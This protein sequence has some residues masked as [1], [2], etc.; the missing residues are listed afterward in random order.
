M[1]VLLVGNVANDF[2]N[3]AKALRQHTNVEADLLINNKDFLFG[4]PKWTEGNGEDYQYPSWVKHLEGESIASPLMIHELLTMMNRYDIV[5]TTPPYGIF[6]QFARPPHILYEC[7]WI[8]KF[9]FKMDSQSKLARR[10]YANAAYVVM[11]NCKDYDTLN[12]LPYIRREKFIPFAID[13]ERYRPLHDPEG[14]FTIFNPSAL[15]WNKKGNDKL[16][17]AYA[18]FVKTAR[19]RGRKPH[20][21]MTRWGLPYFIKKTE[22]LVRDLRL[23]P[24]VTIMPP[25]P[26]YQLIDWYNKAHVVSDQYILGSSGTANWEAASC[27]RPTMIYLDKYWHTHCFGEMPPVLNVYSIDEIYQT[28]I[29]CL[30]KD[31]RQD[32]GRQNRGYVVK[33]LSYKPVAEQTKKLYEEVLGN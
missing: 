11:T 2:M 15:F 23:T 18:R 31:F 1:R 4:D 32:V 12:I 29:R 6:G 28:L 30:D 9:P 25:V 26:H 24:H 19:Q 13:T 14:D 17:Y 21:Y 7:G 8:H 27:G 33:H 5:E 22:Q 20:L 3:L 10:A 16:L